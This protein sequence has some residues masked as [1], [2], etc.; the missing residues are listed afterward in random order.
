MATC[1]ALQRAGYYRLVGVCDADAGR[2]DQTAARFGTAAYHRLEA[3]L[4]DLAR[5]AP[6]VDPA[7]LADGAHE[8]ALRAEYVRKHGFP[9][10]EAVAHMDRV[11]PTNRPMVRGGA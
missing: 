1:A 7:A 4:D 9:P 3:L 10:E 6:A 11:F 5:Q 2:A 8:V